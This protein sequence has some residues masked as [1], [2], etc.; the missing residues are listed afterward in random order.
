MCM[1]KTIFISL[2]I[3]FFAPVVIQSQIK[4][5]PGYLISDK[6]DTLKGEVKVNPKKEQ[7]LYLKVMF[8]DP[9]GAQKNW[10]P[11]KI[12]G[13]GF[14][15]RHFI[16]VKNNDEDMFFECLAV[17]YITLYR[18]AFEVVVMN[19]SK[20]D[21]EYYVF[22]EG[23]KKYTE[24]KENKFKK[25]MLDWMKDNTEFINDFKDEKKFNAEAAIESINQF[26]AWKKNN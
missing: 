6:G 24:V 20:F 19:E 1:N 8:K 2:L 26:N 17:G 16:S 22:K 3:V 14:E 5:V 18:A 7:D 11:A 15:N 13:Y 25:Q 23:D 9:S 10:K 21:F 4:F 12:K